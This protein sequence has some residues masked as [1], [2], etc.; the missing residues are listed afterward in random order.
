MFLVGASKVADRSN[1][2]EEDGVVGVASSQSFRVGWTRS[3]LLLMRA[4]ALLETEEFVF[5]YKPMPCKACWLTT[6]YS[7][8]IRVGRL[9]SIGTERF[10]N[11][12]P[13]QVLS[14]LCSITATSF[15]R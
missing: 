2:G 4:C 8:Q 1:K 15:T 12:Q 10:D 13:Q 9:G 7:I 6:I 14:C 3:L 11:D 5:F